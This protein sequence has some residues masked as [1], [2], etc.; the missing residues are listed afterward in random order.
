MRLDARTQMPVPTA[1]KLKSNE[2]D[3]GH[4]IDYGTRR[5]IASG[6]R[7]RNETKAEKRERKAAVKRQARERR[8][9]KSEM[10]N[11]FREEYRAQNKHEVLLGVSKVAV[12]F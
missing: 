6:T 7:S 10:K 9:L 2:H 11:A 3:R 4:E 1:A 8:A 5:T 12:Q